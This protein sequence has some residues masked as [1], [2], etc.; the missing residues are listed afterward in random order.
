MAADQKNARATRAKRRD[1]ILVALAHGLAVVITAITLAI[2]IG[3]LIPP[4]DTAMLG[5][6]I[7]ASECGVWAIAALIVAL[8]LANL[9]PVKC[10]PRIVT[11]VAALVA[12]VLTAIPLLQIPGATADAEREFTAVFGERWQTAIPA[13]DLA[14]M[15]PASFTFRAAFFGIPDSPDA[16]TGTLI[17]AL[18]IP[19]GDG[20]PLAGLVYSSNAAATATASAIAKPIII[21]IHGGGWHHGDASEAADCNRY[22]AAHGWLVY[23]IEYRLAPATHFP[24]QLDDV[25]CALAWIAAHAAADGG[26]AARMVLIGR[27]AGAE[28]AQIAGFT[29]HF[30]DENPARKA[31]IKGIIAWYS[32]IDMATAITNPSHPDPLDAA[33]LIEDYLGG[34]P[35]QFPERYRDASPLSYAV[36]DAVPGTGIPPLLLIAGRRDHAV[37]IGYQRLYHERQNAAGHPTALIEIP[38]AEHACDLVSDGP[39][40][41][42]GL[43][44]LERFAAWAIHRDDHDD[45][46]DGRWTRPR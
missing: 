24:G 42:F 31:A 20:T 38:W 22:L 41:Q 16:Q 45:P 19:G 4:W 30:L 43:F 7:I 1:R 29:M 14:A 23:A 5:V 27:S 17:H 28:L 44:Y 9:P 11:S 40:A 2:L 26:D 15:R 8:A 33:R 37:L 13:A 10:W 35:D 6:H 25:R 21:S 32:P 46:T 36:P 39:S 12:I 34:D 18:S 3:G